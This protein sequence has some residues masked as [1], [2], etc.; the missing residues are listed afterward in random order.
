[1]LQVSLSYSVCIR[2]PSKYRSWKNQY[3]V[4]LYCVYVKH[5]DP[6]FKYQELQYDLILF[7]KQS[8]GRN[9]STVA[10]FKGSVFAHL[11][12]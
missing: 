10:T 3:N 5:I 9:I 12:I 7:L 6:L 4:E 2:L 8:P 11:F 1:M